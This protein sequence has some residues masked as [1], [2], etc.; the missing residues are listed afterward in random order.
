MRLAV[1]VA[2]A[3]IILAAPGPTEEVQAMIWR[4]RDWRAKP[5]ATRHTLFVTPLEDPHFA[6]VLFQRLAQPQ[7]VA[8]AKDGENTF[9]EFMLFAIDVEKLV[10]K[11]LHQRLCHCQSQFAHLAQSLLFSIC[12]WVSAFSPCYTL[13][14]AAGNR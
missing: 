14:T 5:V 13:V 11:E 9:Y 6:A 4:R 10:I 1:A 2:A 12:V 3:V 7:H 8:V